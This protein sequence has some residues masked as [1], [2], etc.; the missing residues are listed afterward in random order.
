MT[1]VVALRDGDRVIM[2][3][4]SVGVS[5]YSARNRSDPK[6][7]RVGDM[8][9]GFTTS[10]RMG[11]ILG[12]SLRPAQPLEG[13]D[14]HEYMA[15]HFVDVVREALKKGGATKVD[16]NVET[17]G[18]FLVAWRGRIFNVSSDFQVGESPDG[19][20]AVGCGEEIA[21]VS[22][23]TSG[24]LIGMPTAQDRVALALATAA[25]FSIGV[26]APFKFHDLE[27]PR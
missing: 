18:D 5:G 1:C 2:G 10:Y 26:R 4:D 20:D 23:Y 19:Y 24:L 21:R 13:V 27:V 11:Q 15:T 3:C 8:L 12:Y 16:N 22:L 17:C 14:L 9:I 6:V 25:E 7:Y